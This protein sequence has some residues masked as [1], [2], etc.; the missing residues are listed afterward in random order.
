MD[1]SSTTQG[2]PV[3]PRD[4]WLG[5]RRALLAREKAATR[6]RDSINADRLALPWVRV[7]KTY[8]FETSDGRKTL[9]D[10]F[11][12]RSQLIVY[13]FMLG[14]D[15][16]AGCTGC[17]FLADHLDGALPHLEHHDVTLVA[18]SRAPL[19]KID[20]YKARMG[21][22]F[23][24]VS[25]FGSDFNFD[26]DVSFTKDELARPTFFYNFTETNSARANDE[27]PGLS[28]FLKDADGTVY[29]TYSSYARGPEELIGT[30][31]ILDR[32]P[33]GRNETQTMNFVRRHDEYEDGETPVVNL[34][35]ASVERG[36]I[37]GAVALTARQNVVRVQ[38]AGVQ[39]LTAATPMRRD[40]IFRIASMTKP[41]TA[42]A[43]MILV[44][45]GRIALHDPVEPWLPELANRRV[46]RSLDAEPDDTVAAGRPITLDDLLT[47]R[48]GL[49]AV[50]EPAGRY[51]IQA[52]MT[53]L[54]VAPGPWP[55]PFDPDEFMARIG[56][57]PLMHQPGERWMYHTGA[58]ILAVLIARI[59]GMKLEDFLQERIFAPLAMRDT[60]FS[61]PTAALHR[62]ASGYAL[63]EDGA[64]RE[65]DRARGGADTRPPTFPNA[66]VSTA[67][68][69]LGFARMLLDEGHGPRGRVL[70]RE[71][72][73][74]MMT[75]HITPA[76]K[77]V[78]PF[79]PGFWQS[80]GWGYGGAV[81]L[82][83]GPGRPGSYGWAGGFGTTVL[84]DPETRMTTIVLTQRLM[85]GPDDAKLHTD[86][87]THVY[88]AL[89]D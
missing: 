2:H 55:L 18:V 1:V 23:P 15:W 58:D 56:R 37:A 52:M 76:Q 19:G 31:M 21:W 42:A 63:D 66:L 11:A 81:T 60:G 59:S 49:G 13:H 4:E 57:M 53:D 43:A 16:T 54:G 69:Y 64:L 22:R 77:D 47:F 65:A 51:P 29:H 85:Q 71:S 75:D 39:D 38:T 25:S 26:Y 20:A 27:L 44:E 36:E 45:E 41:I 80:N 35:R 50:M 34:L 61:V 30:L 83:Q 79:F 8:T 89:S 68:D 67:D 72:V 28:A 48:L 33:K 87:Q 70:R 5:A 14:P 7:E 73:R 17:S 46:L 12:G 88:Q 9:G 62:L 86:V 74:L 6:L 84:V 24:W 82:G 40:T 32:A 10:L 3:L 78:S